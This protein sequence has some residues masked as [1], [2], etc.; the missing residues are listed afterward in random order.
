MMKP[1]RNDEATLTLFGRTFP[2]FISKLKSKYKMK[3]LA[4]C[5]MSGILILGFVIVEWF[6]I[7]I[8][9]N[10]VYYCNII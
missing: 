8:I 4:H 7:F 9:C 2:N 3:C 1:M 5:W 6:H 10:I